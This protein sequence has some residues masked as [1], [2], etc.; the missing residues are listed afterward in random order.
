MSTL[1][2][3]W[4]AAALCLLPLTLAG[5]FNDD[6]PRARDLGPSAG[7]GSCEAQGRNDEIRLA[8]APA[9]EGCHVTGNKPFFASLSA[10]ETGL[11]YD[12]KYV[13]RGDPGNSVLVQMLKG[14][15]PGSYAQMPPGQHYNDLV[16]S[17]RVTLT[18]EQV[19]A[20][21]QD[22]PAPPEQ[23]ETPSP[24][25]FHVRRLTA[26]EMVV[27]LMEQLGL[28]LEDFVSTSDP[29][30]RNTAYTVNGGK[31]FV[32]PG[33]WSPGISGQYVSDSRTPERFEALGGGN[34]LLYRKRDVGFG[35]SAAQVLVQMSQAWCARAVDKRNNTA[36][37]RHAT[38]ADTSTK[39][40]DAVRKN[41][42]TLYLRMLGQPPSEAEA[43]ALYDQVYLPLE[44]QNTR[45][46]WIGVCAA[47]IRHPLWI[48][49]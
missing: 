9:C 18:I 15:A 7:G 11:V 30:W 33:D 37:L 24:A 47:L 27:S 29:N 46:A 41:L 12:E 28:T 10:F 49:Y 31:F 36:V 1:R 2:S 25:E 42:T 13:K 38:L 22:L 23:L 6:L 17:G 40:P 16:A 20:W 8:L 35:P 39:N 45:L 34:S 32:W 43:K 3:Q 19:E 5:C 44:Q 48:T 21:I 26:E 14:V 4:R